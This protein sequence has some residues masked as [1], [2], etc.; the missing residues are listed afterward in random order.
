MV[1]LEFA[2]SLIGAD[3]FRE[4][5][6]E[7]RRRGN[8]AW[9]WPE[10][11]VSAWAE[12]SSRIAA[13]IS[14]ILAGQPATLA[15]GDPR[16]LSI[17]CYTAGV[18]PLLGWWY[19]KGL[20]SAAPEI[21]SLL[22]LHLDHARARQKKME[23]QCLLVLAALEANA[24]PVVV[25][26]GGDTANRYFP[27]PATRP[28]S[29]F[30]VLVPKK[31]ASRAEA[32]LAEMGLRNHGRQA[33]E[34]SWT[35]PDATGVPRSVWLV[36]ADDPWSVDLH[37]SLDFAA[38]PGAPI[39]R[40]DA[41]DPFKGNERWRLNPSAHALSQPL[42]LLHLAV[43]A[44]GGLHSLS[45]LRMVEIV[46]VVRQDGSKGIL[47][48]DDF[49]TLARRTNGLGPAY[50]ALRMSEQLAPG[51]IPEDVLKHCAGAAPT[52]ART[53]LAKLCPGNAQR[54][55]R[56]SI[57]EHFMWV[58][59][60]SGWFRQLRSDLAPSGSIWSTYQARMYRLLRRR[61]TR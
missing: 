5:R 13:S 10:V 57:A 35:W 22:S 41:A 48:W 59:G 49:I 46:L 2:S 18:G 19:E 53:V 20:L 6:S 61:I 34:S 33:R 30:D 38:S 37:W 26:K 7:A 42:L 56:A 36:H 12:A 44:S 25:L 24:I 45:M 16:A 39:I 4:R 60:A 32:V 54:I 28:A 15:C 50:P 3:E 55:E 9:L 1:S 8:P 27:D 29:D 23:A 21:G 31:L 40:L 52:R 51:T 43:H 17:A 14:A 47:S 58:S 11:A